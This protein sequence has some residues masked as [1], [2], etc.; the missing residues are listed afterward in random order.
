VFRR[1]RGIDSGGGG[2]GVNRNRSRICSKPS[3]VESEREKTGFDWARTE[4]RKF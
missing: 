4:E 3:F 2:G 1:H